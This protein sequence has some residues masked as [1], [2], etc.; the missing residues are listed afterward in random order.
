MFKLGSADITSESLSKIQYIA[1]ISNKPDFTARNISV[2][3][4]TDSKGSEAFNVRLSKNVLSP[5]QA[6]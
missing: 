1:G 4:H 3:G 6:Y 5:S 2:E